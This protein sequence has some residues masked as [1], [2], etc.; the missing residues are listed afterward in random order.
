M[1]NQNIYDILKKLK[2]KRKK[3][4][5]ILYN[6]GMKKLFNPDVDKLNNRKVK[7]IIDTY[8]GVDDSACI[9]YAMHDKN[10][11][12]KLFTTVAGNIPLGI[13][14]RNLLHLLDLF[15]R[16]YPVA[17][18][19]DRAL[20]RIS[21]TAEHMHGVEGLGGYAPPKQ[22]KRTIIGEDAV[23]AMYRVI[24][25]GDGDVV[26]VMLGPQTNLAN[27]IT[28]HPDVIK[29]IPKVVVMG[30]SPFGHKDYPNHISFNLST[31]P[32]AFKVVLDT[33][34][35][36]LMCPSHMG[37]IKAHLEE[38]FV[39]SLK[40]KGDVGNFLYQMYSTYWEPNYPTKRI[41][42]ND[43]C[44]LFALVYPG[45]F[46]TEPATVKVNVT[47]APGKTDIVFEPNGNVEFIKDLYREEF[48]DMLDFKLNT[49]V[50]F[51]LNH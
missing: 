28:T 51:R 24:M 46:I 11:D 29:K 6:N 12:I 45:L 16:D 3:S 15:D 37:R 43:T 4:I 18:G 38:D 32:D 47:D 1:K 33:G 13:A 42:T 5:K 7:V 9:I 31:D 10:I 14:T 50:D 36:V 21:P 44:A 41:T 8:P 23:S 35:P 26:P 19:A 48:L 34:I 30:G 25:E 49:L 39:L 27:L 22:A 17:K 40:T 20:N 2:V